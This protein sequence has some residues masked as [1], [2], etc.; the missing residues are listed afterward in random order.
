MSPAPWLPFLSTTG[1][2][3]AS[4]CVYTTISGTGTSLATF[5][6]GT[7][8]VQNANPVILD[9]GGFASI[10]L[11]NSSYRFA[12]WSYGSGAVGTNCG[13]GTLQRTVDNVSAYTILNQAQN[14]FLSGATSDPSGSAGELAYR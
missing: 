13:N 12:I 11:A 7:G 4:G 9:A 14:I 6:D 3:L 10:W 8:T 5:T 2:P 1:V